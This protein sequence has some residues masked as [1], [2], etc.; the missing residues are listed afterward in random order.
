MPEVLFV[1]NTSVVLN[2]KN[3]YSGILKPQRGALKQHR[4]KKGSEEMPGNNI[5]PNLTSDQYF[6][7]PIH[8]LSNFTRKWNVFC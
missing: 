5:D 3:L 8:R 2:I 4:V 1:N 7:W 6:F